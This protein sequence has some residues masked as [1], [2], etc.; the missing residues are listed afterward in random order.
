MFIHELLYANDAAFVAHSIADAQV[1]CNSFAA[2]WIDFGMK[3]SLSKS[4][5]LVQGI[6]DPATI[7]INDVTLKVVEKFCYLGSNVT[8]SGSLVS[9]LDACIGKA[10]SMFGKLSS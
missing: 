3:I 8:A 5:V 7:T 4:V 1:L 2:A 9:E 6:S 10:A